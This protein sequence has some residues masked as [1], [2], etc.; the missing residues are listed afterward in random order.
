MTKSFRDEI[1]EENFSSKTKLF[2][3]EAFNVLLARNF[4]QYLN[5]KFVNEL[6][7]E[8]KNKLNLSS[9]YE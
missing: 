7:S 1:W 4:L 6:E 9:S 3:T 2:M 5:M 8:A